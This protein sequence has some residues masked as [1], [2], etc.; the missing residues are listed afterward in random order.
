MEE[1]K[2]QEMRHWTT[3]TELDPLPYRDALTPP[4][5]AS[6]EEI[7]HA[8]QLRLDLRR[9]YP[10]LPGPPPSFWHIGVD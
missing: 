6:I 1:S 9:R 2:E 4:V 7:W 3:E 8:Q 5:T 10:D